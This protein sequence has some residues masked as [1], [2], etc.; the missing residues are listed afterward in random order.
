MIINYCKKILTLVNWSST[1]Q[2]EFNVSKCAIMQ[3]T[4]KRSKTDFTY[5]MKGENLE[6]VSHQPYLGVELCSNLKYNLHIDQ[7]CKKASRVLGFI[8]RNL[9]HCPPSVKERA[10]T[11]LVRPK[12]EY[13]STIWNPHTNNNI[14][15][16][17]SVQKNAARFVLNKPHNYKKPD[18]TTEMV[19]N[20]NS[21]TLDQRRKTFDVILLY[22]VVHHL[23]AVPIQHR[24]TMAEIKSTR[25]SHAWNFR[26]FGQISMCTNTHSFHEQSYYGTNYHRL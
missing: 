21:E 14:N 20:L 16:L 9:K 10:N 6:K 22:K 11:S 26:Q 1:W 7:T 19:K 17:E 13:C 15:K 23:I 3:A 2:M 18:S 24:P 25:L 4:N 8:K 12:L 5:E